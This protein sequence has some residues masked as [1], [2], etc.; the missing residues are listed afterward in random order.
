MID[1]FF[2]REAKYW[3]RATATL[4]LSLVV[5]GNL[6]V[7]EQQAREIAREIEDVLRPAFT[8]TS[9]TSLEEVRRML[10]ELGRVAIR[11]VVRFSGRRNMCWWG[12][13]VPAKP[14]KEE[15]LVEYILGGSDDENFSSVEFVIF[16]GWHAMDEDRQVV[17]TLRRARVVVRQ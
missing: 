11:C 5:N 1:K 13:T 6:G 17:Y 3:G 4:A 16:G 10:L 8:P 2:T 12:G 7:V 15:A 9:Q 14:T